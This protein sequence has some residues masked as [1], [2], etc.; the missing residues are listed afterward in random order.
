M[1]AD[2]ADAQQTKAPAATTGSMAAIAMA[3][4]GA[5]GR[6]G[7]VRELSTS[8]CFTRSTPLE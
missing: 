7:G 5:L 3:T 2:P 6:S 1:M 8:C 4:A